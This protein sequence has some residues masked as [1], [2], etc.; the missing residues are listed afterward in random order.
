MHGDSGHA[1]AAFPILIGE[2]GELGPRDSINRVVV[3]AAV[4][5]SRED[6]SIRGGGRRAVMFEIVVDPERTVVA[7][8][9]IVAVKA[10]GR[11]LARENR[12]P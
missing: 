7:A 6:Y 5:D 3:A 9:T 10:Q 2:S 12:L 8:V 11:R 1:P 4:A